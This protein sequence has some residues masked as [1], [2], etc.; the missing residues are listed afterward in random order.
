MAVD[1]IAQDS[2]KIHKGV[3][4]IRYGL[5]L[6]RAPGVEGMRASMKHDRGQLLLKL[7]VN[8]MAHGRERLHAHLKHLGPPGHSPG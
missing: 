7:L 5:S 4:G 8:N 3:L 1:G 6:E 2:V